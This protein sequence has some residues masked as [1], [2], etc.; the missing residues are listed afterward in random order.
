M[1]NYQ[2]VTL[3]LPLSP[4]EMK[5][6]AETSADLGKNNHHFGLK[7]FSPSNRGQLTV[8]GCFA[9]CFTI[10]FAPGTCEILI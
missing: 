6:S 1:L 5:K 3:D 8:D 2:R 4:G 7:K 9:C 10:G